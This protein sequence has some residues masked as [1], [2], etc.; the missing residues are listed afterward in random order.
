ME[1]LLNIELYNFL[2]IFLRIGSGIMVM[3]GFNASYVNPRMRLSIALAVTLVLVPFLSPI[4]PEP[5]K[6]FLEMVKMCLFEIIYGVFLG[7]MMQFLYTA[8]TLVGNFAGQ[9]IGF[10][11]AQAFDPATENQSI[12]IQSFLSLLALTIIFI[13]DLH[14]LMLGAAVDSYHIFPVGSPLPLGDFNEFLRK[15]LNESFVV[16]FK[17]SAPFIA[18]SIIFYS[19]MGLVSR[20]MPQLNVFFL[21]LPLQIYL[22]TGLLLI[23]TPT[24]I[25]WFL[26]YY[27]DG[28]YQ[29]TH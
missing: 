4:M 16:G 24:I 12:V 28:I 13:T 23:T 18:F 21:S 22:G 14:H 9:S 17:L 8:L 27:E 11:N 1:K 10:A 25:I 3:P 15:T 7:L 26:K 19:G 2:F 6:D 29:F 5:P 20:L